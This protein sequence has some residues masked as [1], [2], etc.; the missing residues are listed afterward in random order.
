[1]QPSMNHKP[2]TRSV[3]SLAFLSRL[4]S[5]D[6]AQARPGHGPSSPPD[7][8]RW[9]LSL[10]TTFIDPET[11][12]TTDLSIPLPAPTDLSDDDDE[13]LDNEAVPTSKPQKEQPQK[14]SQPSPS[15]TLH[16]SPDKSTMWAPGTSLDTTLVTSTSTSTPTPHSGICG[17]PCKPADTCYAFWA[18]ASLALLSASHLSS[19]PALRH[20]L[21]ALT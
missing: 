20:Y 19:T 5:A 18:G 13:E 17:R 6:V 3:R 21:L 14:D 7:V 16:Q 2:A 8:V 4:E 12:P 15:A 9:L 11:P 1:M 10:Q